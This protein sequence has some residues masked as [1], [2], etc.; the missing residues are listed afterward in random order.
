MASLK[1][2]RGEV[3]WIVFDPA[4]GTE[5]KKQ[6]P[7]IVLSNDNSNTYLDRFQ[8]VPLTANTSRVYASECVVELKKQPGKVMADQLRTVSASRFG[9]QN[10][11]T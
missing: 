10:V 3:W 5:T 1:P 9:A 7:V 2:K 8:V 6:H 4:Q 11:H